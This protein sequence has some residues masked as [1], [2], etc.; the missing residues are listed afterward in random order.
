[1]ERES[2]ATQTLRCME[3]S[4]A[5]VGEAGVTIDDVV[6]CRVFLSD[7]QHF[8]EFDEIYGKY[9]STPCSATM[10]VTSAGI[11]DNLDVD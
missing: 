5:I 10:T 8:S 3:K 6:S 4:K 11:Y 2:V 1:M 7:M 9:S